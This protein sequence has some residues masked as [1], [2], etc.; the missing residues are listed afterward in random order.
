MFVGSKEAN[1]VLALHAPG[2]SDGVS[3]GI[4][5]WRLR[6]HRARRRVILIVLTAV[7][8]RR[9]LGHPHRLNR[10]D[11]V[12]FIPLALGDEYGRFIEEQTKHKAICD[13][14]QIAKVRLCV[15]AYTV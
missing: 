10:V 9:G 4:S 14:M 7:R 13:D 8:L 1:G 15:V 3:D 11:P 2:F 5:D 6:I 12:F